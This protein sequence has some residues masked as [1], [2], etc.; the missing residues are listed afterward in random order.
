VATELQK[1]LRLLICIQKTKANENK[2]EI[3]HLYGAI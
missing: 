2:Q 3:C 1:G